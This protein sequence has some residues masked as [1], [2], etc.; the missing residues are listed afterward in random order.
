MADFWYFA[1]GSNMNLKWMRSIKVHPISHVPAILRD[2]DLQFNLCFPSQIGV[3][4]GFANIMPKKGSDVHGV[5]FKLPKKS[6]WRMNLAEGAFVGMYKTQ[7]V[8]LLHPDGHMVS[9]ITYVSTSTSENVKPGTRY[10]NRV[11]EGAKF[12]KLP[13]KWISLLQK[14]SGRKPWQLASNWRIYG[15]LIPWFVYQ[16]LY[17][18]IRHRIGI[19]GIM[20]TFPPYKEQDYFELGKYE[21]YQR[22]IGKE[23]AIPIG[24][25][26]KEDLN[27]KAHIQNLLTKEKIEFPV[28]VKPNLGVMAAGVQKFNDV[29]SLLEFLVDIPVDYVIQPYIDRPLEFNI[30]Y[31]KFPDR[32]GELLDLSQRVLPRVVGD[33]VHT[34]GELIDQN[35]YWYYHREKVKSSC[36]VDLNSI[37]LKNKVVRLNVTATGTGGSLFLDSRHLI[38]DT[39]IDK[40]NKHTEGA[41]FYFGKFDFKVSSVEELQ[42]GKG[43]LMLEANPVIA[44]VNYVFDRKYS[45]QDA[46]EVMQHQ[47]KLACKIAVALKPHTP[48]PPSLFSILKK[49]KDVNRSCELADEHSK[50][51]QSRLAQKLEIVKNEG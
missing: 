20:R 15:P 18:Q 46:K 49:W 6:L 13:E 31:Y 36:K 11:I 4:S 40:I 28:I 8:E 19:A 22:F 44:E 1:Y 27:D 29:E 17:F 37:P 32:P 21:V 39:L 47:Y 23:Y 34:V 7:K 10:L 26:R 16:V 42:Q 48:T 43:L 50:R 41:D 14:R 2:Y 3:V 45:Y 24:V 5:L 30:N 9:A 33:G 38:T 51:W 25:I 12:H 35:D